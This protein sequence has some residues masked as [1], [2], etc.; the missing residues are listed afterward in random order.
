MQG[1]F[2]GVRRG[3]VRREGIRRP[4]PRKS[5][6]ETQRVG[7]IKK[8]DKNGGKKNLRKKAILRFDPDESNK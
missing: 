5:N 8:W 7:R 3:K 1:S 2:P 6:M 4:K